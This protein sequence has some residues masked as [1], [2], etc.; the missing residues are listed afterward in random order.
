MELNNNYNRPSRKYVDIT[1]WLAHISFF[2]AIIAI[3]ISP[4]QDAILM[5]IALIL[6][7]IGIVSAFGYFFAIGMYAKKMG[8]S[9][10]IWGG[11]SMFCSPFS[12]WISYAASFKISPKIDDQT[13]KT[14]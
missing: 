5:Y 10:I 8:K 1:F 14:D 6:I 12:A 3:L 11:G 4:T 13:L 9:P 7:F 2:I